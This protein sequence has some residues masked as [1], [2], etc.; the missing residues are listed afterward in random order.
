MKCP[1]CGKQHPVDT[2]VCP[3]T[4][5]TLKRMCLNQDCSYYRERIFDIDQEYCPCCGQVL[6]LTSHEFVDLGLSVKWGAYNVG[7][8]SEY[9]HGDLYAWGSLIPNTSF[10][11]KSRFNWEQKGPLN[12]QND[13]AN[14]EW[15]DR[16]RIPTK[17]KWH[18]LLNNCSKEWVHVYGND[19]GLRLTSQVKG[20]EGKSIFLP[21]CGF[22]ADCQEKVKYRGAAALYWSSTPYSELEAYCFKYSEIS[23]E[24]YGN[25]SYRGNAYSIRPVF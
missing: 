6:F 9:E 20:F 3:S 18:E 16:W 24:F 13:V 10:S 8:T 1:L 22:M 21:A 23:D 25:T 11:R 2:Q 5:E 17:R 7:A 19:Y 12:N 15:H 4:G 14:Q